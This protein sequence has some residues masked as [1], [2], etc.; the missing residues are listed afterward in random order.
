MIKIK[1]L[2]K[3]FVDAN[4]SV[5]VFD[6]FNLEIAQ[7][8]LVIIFG[9]SGC[10]KSTLINLMT[11][12]ESYGSGSIE[13]LHGIKKIGYVSQRNS[14]LP[15][16][17]VIDNIAFGLKLQGMNKE[18]RHK[19]ALKL[20]G[21]MDLIGYSNFYPNQLSG[22][23]S[24]LISFA[25]SVAFK[26]EFMLM[27]EPFSSLDFFVRNKLQDIILKIHKK[28]GLTTVFVTHQVDEALYLGDR[29]IALSASKPTRILLELDTK[30]VKDK[31]SEFF[32]K[33]QRELL[34]CYQ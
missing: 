26:A 34:S 25:R 31:K 21:E 27:D 4:Q 10:G 6:N 28:R 9:P 15:W 7:N 1:N 5:M 29:V 32:Y 18:S 16:L 24:Q 14:L 8:E 13:G 33:L 23:L 20:L 2:S 30:G 22:G 3:T 12:T 17:K 11:G 19:E